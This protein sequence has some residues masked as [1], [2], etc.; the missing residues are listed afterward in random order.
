[1][2]NYAK[3]E[4]SS[5]QMTNLDKLKSSLSK[6]ILDSNINCVI[7]SGTFLGLGSTT[8]LANVFLELKKTPDF[9]TIEANWL[10]WTKAKKN[11]SN[12][13]FVKPLWGLTVSLSDAIH[14]ISNDPV[15][16]NHS[17]YPDIYIDGEDNPIDFYLKE[18]KG[19]FGYSRFQFLNWFYSRKAEKD[20]TIHFSGENLLSKL[21]NANQD[22]NILVL[23]DSCGGIGYLEFQKLLDTMKDRRFHLILDDVHHLKHFRSYQYVKDSSEFQII[24]ENIDNGWA[25]AKKL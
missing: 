5:A 22:K 23:L 25:F 4:N 18:I 2:Q 19:G 9:T 3:K 16:L 14:F 1:M 10:N 24:E 12:L 21:L 11:L 6:E 15:L 20:R 7:E 13:T 17:N 8:F